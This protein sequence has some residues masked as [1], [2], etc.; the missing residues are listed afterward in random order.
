VAVVADINEEWV[1]PLDTR[2]ETLGAETLWIDMDRTHA[3]E[4]VFFISN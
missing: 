3:C 4:R 1:T 2:M